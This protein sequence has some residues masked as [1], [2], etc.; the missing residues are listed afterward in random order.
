MVLDRLPI[1]PTGKLDRARL[2]APPEPTQETGNVPRTDLEQALARVWCDILGRQSAGLRDNFLAGGGDSL[3]VM[4]LLARISEEFGV[5]VPLVV[6]LG[7]PTVE[8][9][10]KC[11]ENAADD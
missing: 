3:R 9:L 4:E 1:G 2:P 10:V 11:V 8:T 7:S 5:E 6:F